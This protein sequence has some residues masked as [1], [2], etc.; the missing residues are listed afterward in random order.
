[1]IKISFN[2]QVDRLANGKP[3]VCDAG[4]S[5]SNPRWIIFFE[6]FFFSKNLIGLYLSTEET[7]LLYFRSIFD[8]IFLINTFGEEITI[9]DFSGQL[10][11]RF[12]TIWLPFQLLNRVGVTQPNKSYL[13]TDI[14]GVFGQLLTTLRDV[15]DIPTGK[16]QFLKKKFVH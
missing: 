9:I 2:F 6:Y 12:S 5:C 4:D 3:L 1:L 11:Y 7:F 8:I 15:Y 16:A 10:N 13:E 14:L